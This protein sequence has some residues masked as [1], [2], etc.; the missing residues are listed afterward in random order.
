MG[1][2]AVAAGAAPAGFAAQTHS[3]SRCKYEAS[4]WK[5]HQKYWLNLRVCMSMPEAAAPVRMRTAPRKR[6]TT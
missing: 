4:K 1:V 3:P 5:P 2:G 6:S